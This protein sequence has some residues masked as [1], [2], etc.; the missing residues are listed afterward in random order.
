MVVWAGSPG[1]PTNTAVA[2]VV[3]ARV[4]AMEIAAAAVAAT[5]QT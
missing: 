2:V 4:A 5:D 3:A 1:T